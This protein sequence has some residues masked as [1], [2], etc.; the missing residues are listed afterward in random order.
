ML[1][2]NL[3]TET[4]EEIKGLLRLPKDRAGPTCYKDAKD[5]LFTLFGPKE[6]DAFAKAA[7]LVMTGKP[8][9]LAK[10]LVDLL[11]KCQPPL[12]DGCCAVLTVAGLW[13]SRLPDVVK[14]HVAGK[15]LA[16][17]HFE[18]TLAIADAVYSSVCQPTNTLAA[19]GAAAAPSQT[20]NDQ[21]M[22]AFGRGSGGRGNGRGRGNR[23]GRG[24]GSDSSGR[25][26]S[27][28]STNTSSTGSNTPAVWGKKHAD[29]PPDGVCQQHHRFGKIAH[30]CRNTF[31]C[32]WKNHINQPN[33][34]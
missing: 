4:K 22:A 8:S 19:L 24:R 1:A 12:K 3:P 34:Q 26:G 17:D 15:S 29:N 21:T 18:T 10:R 30:F 20:P 33:N 9:Q 28:T 7:A 16:G 2:Q 6:A 14:A 32:P 5:R 27:S 25:G 31:T 23:G 13:T 11:C